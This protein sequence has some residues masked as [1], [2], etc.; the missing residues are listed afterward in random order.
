M[1]LLVCE[2]LPVCVVMLVGDSERKIYK[3]P[4]CETNRKQEMCLQTTLGSALLLLMQCAQRSCKKNKRF[5]RTTMCWSVIHVNNKQNT[6]GRTGV[7]IKIVKPSQCPTLPSGLTKYS[8][9]PIIVLHFLQMQRWGKT[10][11]EQQERYG[12]ADIQRSLAVTTFFMYHTLMPMFSIQPWQRLAEY[13]CFIP[14]SSCH[15]LE[16]HFFSRMN[17]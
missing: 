8:P 12:S 16:W 15:K 1:C 3:Q 17:L 10:L 6:D 13:I 4:M 14:F 9:G 11:K 2:Y 5:H 7:D